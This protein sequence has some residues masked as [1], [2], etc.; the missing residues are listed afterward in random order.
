MLGLLLFPHDRQWSSK[1][2]EKVHSLLHPSTSDRR[3]S[4]GPPDCNENTSEPIHGGNPCRNDPL[5]TTETSFF[6]H[7]TASLMGPPTLGTTSRALMASQLWI[8]SL[9]PLCLA[10]FNQNLLW[11]PLHEV[12]QINLLL[13]S[14]S[15]HVLQSRIR[16][17]ANKLMKIVSQHIMVLCFLHFLVC[18]ILWSQ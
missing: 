7:P 5:T 18:D 11:L 6:Y 17:K 16:W 15:Y 10:H 4:C 14:S 1:S 8:I 2:L 3:P 12:L 9:G 13:S